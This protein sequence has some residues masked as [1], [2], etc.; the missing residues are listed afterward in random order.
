MRKLLALVGAVVF[1]DTMF[2]TAL[3]PL[4]PHY[5]DKY[6]LTKVGAGVLSAAYPAGALVGGI[7]SGLLVARF[8]PR[9]TAILGLLLMAATTLGF[10]FAGSIEVLDTARLLQ[11]VASACAWTAGLAW[12]VG[13]APTARRGALIGSAMAAAIVGA[14]FGP[15]LGW[16]GSAVGTRA[17][18]ASVGAVAL[19]LA[20]WAAVA[21]RPEGHEHQPIGMLWA[22]L[23]SRTIQAGVGFVILPAL[24]FG[25]LSVLA[26]LRLHALGGGSLVIGASYLIAAGFEAVVNPLLGRVSDHR[27]RLLPIRGSLLASAAVAVALPWPDHKLAVAALVVCAGI[28]FGSFWTPAMS[29][30]SDLGEARGLGHG[31]TF[32]LMNTAWAP[33]QALG[34]A[35]G[36]ALA[37]VTRDAVPYLLLAG[38]CLLTF[39]ALWRSNA[40]S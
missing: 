6:D 25:T 37:D 17:V 30:L 13:A 9:T 4:L 7:P 26:P 38:V 8:G 21:P 5:A 28:A 12:L 18:F 32:A 10:G 31:Y 20:A 1:L 27:G 3:T 36:G 35:G 11:G 39:A 29:H 16:I 22:A 34:S 2:F 33:G 23:R 19:V 40:S 15:V 24:L 14:L